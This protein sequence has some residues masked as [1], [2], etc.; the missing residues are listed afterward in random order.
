MPMTI[1]VVPKFKFVFHHDEP[2]SRT[3]IISHSD[4]VKSGFEQLDSKAEAVYD[5]TKSDL[6]GAKQRKDLNIKRPT[7]HGGEILGNK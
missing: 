5:C 6:T 4:T 1:I 3:N 7:W 2:L